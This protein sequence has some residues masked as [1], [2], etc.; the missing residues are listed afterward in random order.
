[1]ERPSPISVTFVTCEAGCIRFRVTARGQT[2]EV[3][4]SH[5]VDPFADMVA[6]LHAMMTGVTFC[7]WG[8]DQENWAT[9]FLA[10]RRPDGL[11]RLLVHGFPHAMFTPV[12][13]VPTM[14]Q[15]VGHVSLDA[16]VECKQVV[17]AFFSAFEA[18]V[19]GASYHPSEWERRTLGCVLR[20]VLP[21]VTAEALAALAPA[22]LALLAIALA[23]W[24][25]SVRESCAVPHMSLVDF[26]GRERGNRMVPWEADG[27]FP[28]GLANGLDVPAGFA[29]LSDADKA[30]FLRAFLD[31]EIGSWSGADLKQLLAG[32]SAI[33][34]SQR[35]QVE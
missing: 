8:V 20:R 9:S 3:I 32:E 13:A 6:W 23:D 16:L 17:R 7:H 22:D 34:I 33:A 25:E 21:G 35:L 4:A 30:S 29:A 26:L 18:F 27:E 31:S 15:G 2:V 24:G 11:A 5:L 28:T 10:V 14:A 1:M 19:H 12:P